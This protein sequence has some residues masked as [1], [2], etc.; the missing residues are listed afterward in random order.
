MKFK[1]TF[2]NWCTNVAC[3]EPCRTW[4]ECGARCSYVSAFCESHGGDSRAAREMAEHKKTCEINP[5]MHVLEG[6]SPEAIQDAIEQ[7]VRPTTE[8]GPFCPRHG[9]SNRP[10]EV[11]GLRCERLPHCDSATG[12][13]G[14]AAAEDA[15]EI[16][17][18]VG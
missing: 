3:E 12:A 8:D 11:P 1:M 5:R 2:K 7:D 14:E 16:R 17:G 10:A 9:R 13:G 6:V 15:E 4:R 18:P